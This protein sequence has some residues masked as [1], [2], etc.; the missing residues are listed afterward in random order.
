MKPPRESKQ[1]ASAANGENI[2]LGTVARTDFVAPGDIS[3]KSSGR[4]IASMLL[5]T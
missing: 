1:M 2:R 5:R 3:M 4:W